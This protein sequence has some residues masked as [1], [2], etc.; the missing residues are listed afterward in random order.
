MLV[1]QSSFGDGEEFDRFIIRGESRRFLQSSQDFS[2]LH[3]IT[4][5]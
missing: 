4:G 1:T 5:I 3:E 2:V